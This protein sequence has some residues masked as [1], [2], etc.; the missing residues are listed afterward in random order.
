MHFDQW[1]QNVTKLAPDLFGIHK[2]HFPDKL[3]RRL[4]SLIRVSP[5]DP[6]ARYPTSRL[7][8]MTLLSAVTGALPKGDPALVNKVAWRFYGRLLR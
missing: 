2:L 4:S 3:Y 5:F 6:H 8:P 7:N 1:F